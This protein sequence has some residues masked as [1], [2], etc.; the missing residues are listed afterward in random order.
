MAKWKDIR[1]GTGGTVKGS[2]EYE[3]ATGESRWELYQDETPFIDQAK[4]DR[5]KETK[6]TAM[7][8]KKFATI[9]DIVAIE[10]AEKYGI[11]I[12]D[13]N[14]MHDKHRMNRFKQI[15]M[16]DYKYLVV[17]NA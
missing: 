8:H 9:P 6:M 7:G 1:S 3:G 4:E 14:I 11:D 13:P 5:E 10:I 15:V 2:I 17:N 12:H 16:T